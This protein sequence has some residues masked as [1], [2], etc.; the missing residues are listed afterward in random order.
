MSIKQEASVKVEEPETLSPKDKKKEKKE[1]KK[2]KKKE[3]LDAE[4][5]DV[6]MESVSR[7]IKSIFIIRQ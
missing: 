1:K 2:K 5:E 7:I 6:T 4:G 3:K